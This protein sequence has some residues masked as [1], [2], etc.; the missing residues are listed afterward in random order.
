MGAKKDFIIKSEDR[1]AQFVLNKHELIDFELTSTERERKGCTHRSTTDSF[2]INSD[3][4]SL[5][6]SNTV[7][8]S[9]FIRKNT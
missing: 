4:G 5:F 7:T 3:R 8:L 9:Y 6:F 2:T 1:I